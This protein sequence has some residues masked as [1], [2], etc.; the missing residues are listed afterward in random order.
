MER[1]TVNSSNLSSVGY[2]E[3]S[4]TLEVEFNH[5]GIYQ[6]YNVPENIY[7]DLMGAGSVGS[8]FSH[9]IRNV[10]PTQKI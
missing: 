6:Y 5:G 3:E 1:I 4:Q 10:Y 9:N 2:D 7:T 8:F